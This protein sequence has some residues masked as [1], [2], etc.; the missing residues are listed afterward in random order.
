MEL[1]LISSVLILK[2]IFGDFLPIYFEGTKPK[3]YALE[4]S[5][6]G[7]PMEKKSHLESI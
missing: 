3:L 4:Y 5:K 1:F 7:A 6:D 2:E